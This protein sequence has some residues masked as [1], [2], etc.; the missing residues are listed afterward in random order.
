MVDFS[1]QRTRGVFHSTE[2]GWSS[3]SHLA[4]GDSLNFR[5][6]RM[7]HEKSPRQ[8][9]FLLQV[10]RREGSIFAS[11]KDG[12][13]ALM[14]DGGFSLGDLD[15]ETKALCIFHAKVQMICAF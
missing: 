9:A 7:T 6:G 10:V 3:S 5:L 15:S 2:H 12:D 1:T 13:A 11:N 14:Q 8:R 4:L